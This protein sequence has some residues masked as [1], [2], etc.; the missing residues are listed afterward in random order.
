MTI[1]EKKFRQ[2]L[3][4]EFATKDDLKAFA[5][6]EDLKEFATKEDLRGIRHDMKAFATKDDLND[7]RRELKALPT[8]E[9]VSQIVET[10]FARS[11]GQISRHFD[12]RFNKFEKRVD[13]RIDGLY[14]LLDGFTGRLDTDDGERA[15]MNNQLDRHGRWIGELADATSTTLSAP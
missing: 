14:N 1:D 5:T 7:I 9:D 8:K 15:A 2:I 11:F 4:E 6:K 10:E 13:G 12:G 3:R